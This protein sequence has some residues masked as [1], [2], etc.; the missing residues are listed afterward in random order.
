MKNIRITVDRTAGV[1]AALKALVQDRVLVGIASQHAFRDPD[2]DD[3]SPDL[4][5]AEIGY[6]N[7]FGAPEA[8]IP[9]RPHLVP[10][11]QKVL[12]K[13]EKIYREAAPKVLDGDTN[14][15][16]GAHGRV[17]FTVT[18]SVK[19]FMTDGVEPALAESTLKQRKR[20]GRDGETP[21][22]D[23]GQ[24]RRNIDFVIRKAGQ[25]KATRS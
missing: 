6:L 15:I 12:P 21:L 25:D 19:A 8:N 3:P 23:T 9:A 2:P 14:A 16:R 5:N 17:G 11:T 10:G 7:E 4:N 18:S 22:L 20:R 1:K 13:V 24:Y